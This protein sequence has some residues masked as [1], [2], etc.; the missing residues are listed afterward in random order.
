[1][2]KYRSIIQACTIQSLLNET[3][4]G[5]NKSN[6]IKIAGLVSVKLS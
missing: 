1:M 5:K 4:R 2:K 6:I 3:N